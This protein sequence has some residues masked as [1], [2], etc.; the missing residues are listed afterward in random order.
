V[1][2][3][4]RDSN[5]IKFTYVDDDN[6]EITICSDGELAEAFNVV[7]NKKGVLKITI[8]EHTVDDFVYVPHSQ[9]PSPVV[10]SM[11]SPAL[12]PTSPLV[13]TPIM[14]LPVVLSA[15][16]TVSLVTSPMVTSPIFPCLDTKTEVKTEVLGKR[17]ACDQV[18]ENT[19]DT[20]CASVTTTAAT[21]VAT[22]AAT[23]AATT[24]TT[25][26]T[27]ASTTAATATTA[28][29]W[30]K[31]ASPYTSVVK[32]EDTFRAHFVPPYAQPSFE[33]HPPSKPSVP[34]IQEVSSSIPYIQEICS[35][36]PQSNKPYF[37][38]IQEISAATA[39]EANKETTPYVVS[40]VEKPSQKRVVTPY[41]TTQ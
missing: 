19:N 21:T 14:V 18:V 8:K 39:T 10:V 29:S 9:S 22:T 11:P 27:T 33:H 5:D 25:A 41:T 32:S 3:S 13:I 31:K 37:P 24:V 23:T 1:F 36:Q 20:S 4:I 34:Y 30:P 6:D 17:K 35:A 26:A 40:V 38:Y 28:K 15:M 16:P 2:P 7:Q 12:I